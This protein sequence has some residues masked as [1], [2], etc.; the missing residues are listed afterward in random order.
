[1]LT[2]SLYGFQ[3]TVEPA[4]EDMFHF[5]K[6][7]AEIKNSEVSLYETDS[8]G[9]GGRGEVEMCVCLALEGADLWPLG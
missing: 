3:F 4:V 7:K 1:M 2:A 8:L 5:C 9:E 6:E